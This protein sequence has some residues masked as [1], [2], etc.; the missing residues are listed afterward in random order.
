MRRKNLKGLT[1]QA[2]RSNVRGNLYDM[3]IVWV[4]SLKESNIVRSICWA[5]YEAACSIL[6]E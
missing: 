5:E 6:L 3:W 4:V 1:I 2:T